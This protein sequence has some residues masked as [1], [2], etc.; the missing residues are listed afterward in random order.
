[1]PGINELR[2]VEGTSRH[3]PC[4]QEVQPARNITSTVYADVLNCPLL[5]GGERIFTDHDG[6]HR[7][8][9]HDNDPSYTKA[10]GVVEQYNAR[11]PT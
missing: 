7:V 2:P 6:R 4:Y 11:L 5:P 9:Q 3:G 10:V 8:F 1:M